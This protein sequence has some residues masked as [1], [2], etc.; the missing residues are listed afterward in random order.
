MKTRKQLIE[1]GAKDFAIRF[2]GV[3]KDLAE[4]EMPQWEKD[5]RA[6]FHVAKRVSREEPL[7]LSTTEDELVEFIRDTVKAE[8]QRIVEGIEELR[9]E[10]EMLPEFVNGAISIA[11]KGYRIALGDVINLIQK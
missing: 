3:M 5:V 9:K 8:R 10:N 6:K 1:E 11:K 4:E 7:S 2:E